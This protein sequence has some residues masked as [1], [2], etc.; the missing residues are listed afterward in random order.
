MHATAGRS[1]REIDFSITTRVAEV[2]ND[3]N[4]HCRVLRGLTSS[5]GPQASDDGLSST[6]TPDWH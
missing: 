3:L 6:D 1:E 4:N 5:R 2:I